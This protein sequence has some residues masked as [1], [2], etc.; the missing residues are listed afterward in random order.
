[1][2]VGDDE[3]QGEFQSQSDP[4]PS[5]SALSNSRIDPSSST[6][7]ILLSS[8]SPDW[9]LRLD[10]FIFWLASL[11]DSA[12]GWKLK[13]SGSPEMQPGRKIV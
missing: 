6:T 9:A 12:F 2:N 11:C 7:K 4:T 13:S 5:K 1:M 8:G 10:L 3:M